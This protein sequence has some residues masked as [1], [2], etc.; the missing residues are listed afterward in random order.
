MDRDDTDRPTRARLTLS[1]FG[2][3]VQ[4]AL[5]AVLT[6][7]CHGVV[8]AAR[9]TKRRVEVGDRAEPLRIGGGSGSLRVL[10]WARETGAEG[11]DPSEAVDAEIAANPPPQPASTGEAQDALVVGGGD[12]GAP[13]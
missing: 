9:A 10:G 3:L 6:P 8:P 4:P 11:S 1:P 13:G 2:V 5:R 7:E 12:G